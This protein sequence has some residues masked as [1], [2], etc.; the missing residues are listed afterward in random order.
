MY[1]PE[2]ALLLRSAPELQDLNPNDLP[3]L[4]TSHYAQIIS[5]RLSNE[6][7]ASD[8]DNWTLDKIADTYEL[9]VSISDNPSVK[10]PSAFVAASAQ[11][12]IARREE[13]LNIDS[14]SL[15]NISRDR[16]APEIAAV[17]LFL[18][19]EQ[20][21]DAHEAASK[22]D[23]DIDGQLPIV[24][25]I[26]HHIIDLGKG[27]LSSIINRGLERSDIADLP[28]N[29]SESVALLAM[30]HSLASGIEGMAKLVLGQPAE[31]EQVLSPQALFEKVK[32]LSSIT[33]DNELT[34]RIE[35]SYPGINHLSSLLISADEG[36]SESP[37]TSLAAP[38]GSDSE[39]WKRWINF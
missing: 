19:A 1:D 11:L 14:P 13:L 8:H 33:S 3:K 30:L 38:D 21:A 35:F 18:A 15:P 27:R 37:L 20:Y 12:I 22:I 36:I 34:A 29:P 26:T 9:M 39:F 6:E 5:M 24:S 7:Q 25:V 4:L 17:L 32:A 23:T 31:H 2:T 16:L 10:R 28:A